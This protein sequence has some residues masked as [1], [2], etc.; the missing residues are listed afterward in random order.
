[1]SDNT[2]AWEI[3]FT[4][5]ARRH[6]IGRASARHVLAT[7]DPTQVTTSSGADA[8]L[9]IGPDERGREL[10]IIALEVADA[11]QPYLLVIHVMPTQLRG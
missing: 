7:T 9:Y 4:Q 6:R 8:W 10:E 1:M 2:S 11:G 5:S 3:R